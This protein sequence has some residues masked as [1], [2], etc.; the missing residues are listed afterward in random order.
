M[1]SP[2][3]GRVDV[4]AA[5]ADV[6]LGRPDAIARVLAP[7]VS[8]AERRAIA[9]AAAAVAEQLTPLPRA[10]F[11]IATRVRRHC[12]A[13]RGQAKDEELAAMLDALQER[14]FELSRAVWPWRRD[15]K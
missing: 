2:R 10:L 1:A 7:R 11:D 9:D 4:R 6:G 3:L 15:A 14:T 8:T 13:Q 5:L 12:A